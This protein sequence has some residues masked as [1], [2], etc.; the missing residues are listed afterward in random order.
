MD[1]DYTEFEGL[2]KLARTHGLQAGRAAAENGQPVPNLSGEWAD[3]IT[4]TILVQTLCAETE[5][6]SDALDADD[7][8]W[9]CDAWEEAADHAH[10]VITDLR[11]QVAG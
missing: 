2:R 7:I 1:I 10:T 5:I 8:S 3:D 4:P 9:L 6:P 11:G